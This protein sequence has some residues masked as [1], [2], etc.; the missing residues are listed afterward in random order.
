[1]LGYGRHNLLHGSV[2]ISCPF[3][4]SVCGLSLFI[5]WSPSDQV[6]ELWKLHFG[7]DK[8]A[9]CLFDY[10]TLWHS[11]DPASHQDGRPPPGQLSP[12]CGG[13]NSLIWFDG[14][15]S[16]TRC[17]HI[18]RSLSHLV[19]HAHTPHPPRE[20]TNKLQN[21]QMAECRCTNSSLLPHRTTGANQIL[22]FQ[23]DLTR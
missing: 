9:G 18:K 22:L 15:K 13:W 11:S 17:S 7:S 6:T 2:H 5:V 21:T 12:H 19:N 8:G 3:R 23:C 16:D 20:K 10:R 4:C 14:L 1:M